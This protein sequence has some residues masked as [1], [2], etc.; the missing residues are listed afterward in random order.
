M[1]EVVARDRP[2]LLFSIAEAMHALHL[3]ISVAKINT[4]GTRVADVFY[5]SE[6]DG[7]KLTAGK[8]SLEVQAAL[9]AALEGM[10]QDGA[11][12]SA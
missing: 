2:G 4:E 7:T 9:L 5:V 8:R 12:R 11:A 3:S 6:A 10:E 1:I